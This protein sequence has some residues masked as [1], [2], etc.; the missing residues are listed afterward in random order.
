VDALSA[1]RS[2]PAFLPVLF[3]MLALMGFGMFKLNMH[4][5]KPHRFYRG[6]YNLRMSPVSREIAGVTLFF[7][8][9][10][11][12]TL[13]SL[14]DGG[15]AQVLQTLFAVLGLLGLGFGGYFM[16]KLYRIA[17]R[18]YWDHWQTA[19][20]FTGTGLSLGALLLALT[21]LAFGA[22]TVAQ[23][24]LLA[25]IVGVGLLL[26]GI[27]LMFHA[28][29]LNHAESE[30]AASFY[31]QSTTYGYAYWL[32]NAL[33]VSAVL[34]AGGMYAFAL[35]GPLAFGVLAVLGLGVA[36]L[37]RAM[38]YV[39]VIP[40]TMPGAFF[41]KNRG[42]V[43]H[44]RETGL[45]DMPQLGVV[46][47]RHHAFKLGELLQTLRETSMKEKVGQFKRIFTG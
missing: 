47:E 22:L 28:R 34:L 45:A 3:L 43:E 9:L 33:L 4:L 37:G 6:F 41:W 7:V 23:G 16:Y 32:R 20:T 29:D 2:S 31:E 19:A 42:F 10:G 17:A 1:Y 13:S 11:G 24:Q 46:Y 25:A 44:A 36:I 26:E 40:T 38:F 18:P 30:A 8:G 14:F 5:G 15:F 27:G 21:G 12:F 35:T 39:M